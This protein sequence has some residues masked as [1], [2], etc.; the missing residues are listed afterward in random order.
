M[1]GL[2]KAAIRYFVFFILLYGTLSAVSFIPAVGNACN[3][4]YCSPTKP[5]LQTLLSKA[6][7][8]LKQIDDNPD[9]IKVEFAS[10]ELVQQQQ[11]A[12]K[13]LG[14]AKASIQGHD[15]EFGFYNLFLSFFLFLVVLILLSPLSKKEKLVGLLSGG[16]LFYFFTVFKM[17]LAL[18]SH[19]NEPEIAVYQTGETWLNISSS[20]LYFMTLGANVLVVLVIWAWLVF[21]KNN[22]KEMLGTTTNLFQRTK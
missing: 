20:I 4:A 19:F 9:I 17:Y 3:V 22:W 5:I 6:Y 12:A 10:K 8:N 14:Q 13:K 15:F 16:L 18:L 1:Q 7:I 21:R 2:L 11:A